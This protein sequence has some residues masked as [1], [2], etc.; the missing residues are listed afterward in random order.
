VDAL[1]KIAR[2][3]R[4]AEDALVA[5]HDAGASPIQAIKALRIGMGLSLIESKIA[6]HSSPA[7]AAE[8]GAAEQFHNELLRAVDEEDL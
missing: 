8:A 2:N 5:L 6:L 1:E 7:W 3:S 4:S